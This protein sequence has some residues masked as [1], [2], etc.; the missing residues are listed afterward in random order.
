MLNS[1]FD[2]CVI[3]FNFKKSKKYPPWFSHDIIK[4]IKLR[5]RKLDEF[6]KSGDSTYNEFKYLRNKI[7][8]YMDIS[9]KHYVKAA[10]DR[11]TDEPSKFWAFLC[12]LK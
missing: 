3:K 8:L 9:Y 4:N 11:I 2:Y 5:A 10:E 1:V 7:K 12:S 6:K